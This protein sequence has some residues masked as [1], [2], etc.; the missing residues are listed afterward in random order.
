MKPSTAEVGS[1]IT[2]CF[3]ESIHD[4]L[5]TPEFDLDEGEIKLIDQDESTLYFGLLELDE[6]TGEL[7]TKPRI[8]WSIEVVADLQGGQ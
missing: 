7:K 2:N 6:A 4:H 3:I 1:R 5:V 8:I